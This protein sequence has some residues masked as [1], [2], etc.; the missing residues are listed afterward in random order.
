LAVKVTVL[1][2]Q[3]V[4]LKD[5]EMSLPSADITGVAIDANATATSAE[6]NTWT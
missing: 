4:S 1:K 5:A 2:P 3:A 6:F